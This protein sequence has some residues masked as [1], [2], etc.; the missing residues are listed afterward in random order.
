MAYYPVTPQLGI[1]PIADTST[2]QNHPLGTVVLA[3]DQTT[4][5]TGE[6]VYLKGVASTTIGLMVKWDPVAGTTTINPDT[7]VLAGPVAIAM[8]ANV[9][10]QY[11]WY[12]ISGAA[13]VKKSAIKI[14]PDVKLYQSATTGRV[15]STS[16][17]GKAVLGMRSINTATVVSAT[18]TV[19][20]LIERPHMQGPIT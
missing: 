16:A 6:F 3:N 17:A 11:G 12:Q 9:A 4:Y 18:S 20:V 1:Q 5:G 7:A 15:M 13:V 2:T 19:T 8:S 14:N 10:S